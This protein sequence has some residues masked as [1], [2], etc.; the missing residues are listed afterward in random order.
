MTA[1]ILEKLNAKIIECE[2]REVGEEKIAENYAFILGMIAAQQII[3]EV[4]RDIEMKFN[5]RAK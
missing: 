2:M 1:K 3:L 5:E 4:M